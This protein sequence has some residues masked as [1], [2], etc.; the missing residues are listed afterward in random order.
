MAAYGELDMHHAP[1]M[2]AAMTALLNRGDVIGINLDLSGLTLIDA[3]GVG[4]IVVAHRIATNVR[5]NLRLTAV[6]PSTARVLRLTGAGELV[7][8]A[9]PVPA[10]R[11]GTGAPRV[12]PYRHPAVRTGGEVEI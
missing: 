9:R 8:A 12:A 5:V 3:C 1:D 2:R 11:I 10:P 6:T 4:T 7:P